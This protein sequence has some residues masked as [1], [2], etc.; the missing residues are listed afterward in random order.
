MISFRGLNFLSQS[1]VDT[2]TEEERLE[3]RCPLSDHA[4]KFW[5]QLLAKNLYPR[6]ITKHGE[7]FSI[8]HKK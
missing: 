4:G 6:E 5:P 7:A 8:V 3:D 1:T 2:A